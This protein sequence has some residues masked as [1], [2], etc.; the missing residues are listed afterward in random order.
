VIVVGAYKFLDR[1]SI[2]RRYG[3]HARLRQQL[4]LSLAS[5]AGYTA[6]T[7]DI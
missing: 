3:N 4:L 5:T 1:A 2:S 6:T 7:R